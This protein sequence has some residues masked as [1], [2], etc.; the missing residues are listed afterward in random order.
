[1]RAYSREYWSAVTLLFLSALVFGEVYLWDSMTY[2]A[3]WRWLLGI[4]P[5]HWRRYILVPA[6]TL[7]WAVFVPH[8]LVKFLW[9]QSGKVE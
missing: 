6:F 5:R 8:I 9:V 4:E 7:L 3:W 1:M 2:S